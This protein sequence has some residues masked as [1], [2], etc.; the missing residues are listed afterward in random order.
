MGVTC[1]DDDND[2]LPSN[3]E[4]GYVFDPQM[5]PER[6]SQKEEERRLKAQEIE[7]RS[8]PIDKWC[9]YVQQIYTIELVF[10]KY[11]INTQMQQLHPIDTLGKH[12]LPRGHVHKV[13]D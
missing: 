13:H 1:S 11:L 8:Q 9:K 12:L 10:I 3:S 7:K 2:A 6:K 4:Q 5:T